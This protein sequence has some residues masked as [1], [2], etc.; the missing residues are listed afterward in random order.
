MDHLLAPGCVW[1]APVNRLLALSYEHNIQAL[2]DP[3]FV[4]KANSKEKKKEKKKKKKKKK[5]NKIMEHLLTIR[6]IF[7]FGYWNRVDN[8]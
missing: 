6:R 4:S 7:C 5:I 1:F 2:A 3:R 8:I